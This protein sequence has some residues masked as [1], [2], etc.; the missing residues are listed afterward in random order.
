MSEKEI[1][2][3]LI[4]FGVASSYVA[5]DFCHMSAVKWSVSNRAN[6]PLAIGRFAVNGNILIKQIEL[7]FWYQL[8]EKFIRERCAN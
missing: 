7:F 1:S 8:K 5:D 6:V 3:K 4:P 2:C